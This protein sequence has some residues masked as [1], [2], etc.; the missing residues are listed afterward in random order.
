MK[1]IIKLKT[2]QLNDI[3]NS[4]WIKKE[5][6]GTTIK[7]LRSIFRLKKDNEIIKDRIIRDIR[8]LFERQKWLL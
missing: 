6:E 1:K 5:I 7:D 2:P 4:L 8:T 3:R